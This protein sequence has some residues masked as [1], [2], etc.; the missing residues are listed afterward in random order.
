[1]NR[2]WII[3]LLFWFLAILAAWMIVAMVLTKL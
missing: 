1:M 3:K 2:L